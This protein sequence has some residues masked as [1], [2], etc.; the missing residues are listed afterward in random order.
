MKKLLLVE[1]DQSLGETLCERLQKE[2]YSVSWV[3]NLGDAASKTGKDHFDLIILDVNLPDGSGFDFARKVRAER[4]T[5]FIFITALNSA[6]HRL[7]GYE[8]GA[9]EF[10]PKPFH[11]KELLLRIRHVLDTHAELSEVR[12]RDCVIDLNAQAIIKSDGSKEFPQARD[13][14]LLKMLIQSTPRVLSRDQILDAVWGEDKYPSHRTVDN[15]IVRLRQVIGD[16]DG[17]LIRSVRGVGYQWVGGVSN[18]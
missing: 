6:E 15:A 18:E 8:I 1:D 16:V 13:F 3:E 9:E 5:P 2:S 4:P 14:R 11:L 7:E 17:S 10:I 12:A